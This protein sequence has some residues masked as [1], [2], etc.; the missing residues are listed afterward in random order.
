LVW[1]DRAES[2]ARGR[3]GNRYKWTVT[4]DVSTFSS[5]SGFISPTLYLLRS[6][7]RSGK[8]ITI[9]HKVHPLGGEARRCK[10]E[11]GKGERGC[12]KNRLTRNF[13]NASRNEKSCS[14]QSL[15]HATRFQAYPNNSKCSLGNKEGKM[16]ASQSRTSDSTSSSFVSEPRCPTPALKASRH[17]LTKALMYSSCR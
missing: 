14:C 10:V 13:P 5:P 4:L 7:S 1:R 11:Q 15:S 3:N 6:L 2:G 17:F 9:K 8:C 16:I 12:I